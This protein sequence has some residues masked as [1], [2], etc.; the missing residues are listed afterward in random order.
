MSRVKGVLGVAPPLA[1]A[2][3]ILAG[4]RLPGQ[5][6]G[7]HPEVTVPSFRRDIAIE[8]DL[9]EEIIRVWGYHRI[10]S[11]L[12]GGP[13]ALV[14]HPATL[15]QSQTVRRALVGA[16][17]AEVIT[18]SFSDPARAALLRRPSDPAPVELLNPLAQDASWLRSNPLEGVLDA[19]ATNV[20][21]QQPD[22]RIFEICK[23]YARAVEA[24]RTGVSEPARTDA[25][26]K[27]GVPEPG[28]VSLGPPSTKAGLTDPATT[29]PATKEP[30]WLPIALTGARGQPGSAGT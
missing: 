21:R 1:Q 12:P 22:V 8:D 7:A 4:L 3:K 14:T 9:V 26:E 29:N 10:P 28:R 16:G 18:H 6:R 11:T 27:T 13:I 25:A 17:L 20:R 24:D 30:R 15:R 23:T 19:V 2:R 5:A